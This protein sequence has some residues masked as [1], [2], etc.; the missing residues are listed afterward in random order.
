MVILVIPFV[1]FWSC[2]RYDGLVRDSIKILNSILK[3][4]DRPTSVSPSTYLPATSN[5]YQPS[6]AHKTSK[7]VPSSAIQSSPSRSV[8]RSRNN[9]ASVSSSGTSKVMSGY[10]P[11]N[12][13]LIRQLPPLV[14]MSTATISH[15]TASCLPTPTTASPVSVLVTSP[16]T[17]VMTPNSSLQSSPKAYHLQRASN[18][19]SPLASTSPLTPSKMAHKENANKDDLV[20]SRPGV[21]GSVM[22]AHGVIKNILNTRP[23]GRGRGR[24]RIPGGLVEKNH[25]YGGVGLHS[26]SPLVEDVTTATPRVESWDDDEVTS[27]SVSWNVDFFL[28][29]SY[30]SFH[31]CYVE[32][33]YNN[34]FFSFLESCV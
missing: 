2:S 26:E 25:G 27:Q 34:I 31:A 3:S 11:S 13:P 4:L 9:S 22:P 20:Y 7:P 16:F 5:V 18:P 6:Y 14:P 33:L 32:H 10:P 28:L 1:L 23:R 8:Q 19:S 30:I 29:L 21:V 12:S 17:P 24:G 15:Y